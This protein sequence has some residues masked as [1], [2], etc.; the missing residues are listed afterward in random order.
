MLREHVLELFFSEFATFIGR[1]RRQARV[2]RLSDNLRARSAHGFNK[3]D[4]WVG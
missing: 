4:E 1:K 3:I 2:R